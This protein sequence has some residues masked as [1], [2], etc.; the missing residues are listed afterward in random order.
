MSLRD[1]LEAAQSEEELRAVIDRLSRQLQKEK[2][3]KAELV[4]AVYRAA[5]DAASGLALDP[6]PAPELSSGE[7]SEEV[8]MPLFSDLQLAKVTPDYD[9]AVAE[10]RIKEYAEKI[11]RLTRIQRADHPVNKCVVMGL[12]DVIEGELIFPGQSY[13]IDSSLYRQVT[14][15]GPRIVGNFTRHLLSEFDEVEWWWVIG[16]HGRIGGRSS[17]DMNP[18]A[19]ADRM[20]GQILNQ[21]F[22]GEDRVRFILADDDRP[23]DGYENGKGSAGKGER[24]WY[25]VGEIGEYR[26][27]LIHGDQFRGHSGLPFYG[28]QKKVN[29]WA[30]GAIPVKFDDV[31]CGHW[32]QSAKIPL[33][34]RHVYVNGSP[35]SY[36]TYAQEN[37]AS[38]TPPSQML[39]YVHPE[40]GRI[41]AEY[42]VRLGDDS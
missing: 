7:G 35:E 16:N 18:E 28:F 36:N 2:T 15:D 9:S 31:L 4:N 8:A 38:M 23:S 14:V 21:M 32:H 25:M 40:R 22:A 3:T 17:R 27:L 34:D 42:D 39:M 10:E 30:A 24:N 41:T 26:P 20:L 11:S 19:N 12:G 29:S 6:V 5:R 13:L 37:M 33:N 1:S